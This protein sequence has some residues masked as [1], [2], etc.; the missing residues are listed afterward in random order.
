[1]II[2][3]TSAWQQQSQVAALNEGVPTV[4]GGSDGQFVRRDIA[5]NQRLS[6]TSR[7][8]SQRKAA[9][10]RARERRATKAWYRGLWGLE[11]LS[12]FL[13]DAITV[14]CDSC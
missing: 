2:A 14:S 4:E 11:P 6:A 10:T 8:I 1:M 3:A 13:T 7:I 5:T 12:A 9:L